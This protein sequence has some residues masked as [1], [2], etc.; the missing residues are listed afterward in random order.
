MCKTALG[1]VGLDYQEFVV[2]D[3]KFYRPAE[4][5]VLLGDATKA[6]KKLDW[7]P[8]T[9]LEQLVEMMVDADLVR[10]E[11]ESMLVLAETLIAVGRA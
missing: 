6:H 9:D 5:E 3:P 1:H 10:V 11:R 4:L 7:K 2:I 8:K